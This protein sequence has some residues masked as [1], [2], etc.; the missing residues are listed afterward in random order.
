MQLFSSWTGGEFLLFYGVL[1]GLSVAVSCWIPLKLRPGGRRDDTLD[2]ESLALLAGGPQR[3]ADSIIA[4]LYAQGGLADAGDG[5]LAVVNTAI[6]TTVAGKAVLALDGPFSIA[7]ARLALAVHAER[8]TARLRRQGLIAFAEEINRLRLLAITPFG[9]L[10]VMGLYR[11]RAGSALNEPTQGLVGLLVATAVAAVIR[12]VS[13][14]SRTAGG[15]E[16]LHRMRDTAERLRRAPQP[17]EAA[18]AVALF[19]TGVLVGTPWEPVHALRQQGSGD[20]S[21]SSDNGNSGGGDGG[22]GGCGG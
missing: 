4:D 22:C 17:H 2:A 21:G 16:T 10:F 9:V 18:L 5:T 14:D 19:G 1:L 8:V 13:L 3:H 20:G 11:E 6:P 15:I 7:A 12:F